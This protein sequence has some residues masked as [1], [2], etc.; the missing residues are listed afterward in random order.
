[1]LVEDRRLGSPTNDQGTRIARRRGMKRN[2]FLQSAALFLLLG[3]SNLDMQVNFAA[4]YATPVPY[5]EFDGLPATRNRDEPVWLVP[6][7]D[8]GP[9]IAGERE[10][11]RTLEASG[12]K[13]VTTYYWPPPPTGI[14]AG[15]TAPLLR[16]KETTIEG[17]TAKPI[18]L[19]G[20]FSQTYRPQHHNFS[21]DFMFEPALEDGLSADILAELDAKGIRQIYVLNSL[22]MGTIDATGKITPL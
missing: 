20:Y 3:I 22:T 8:E 4:D 7:T 2:R 21:E 14:V 5:F 16:W 13:I 19:K 9:A 10:Q 15:Y 6:C 11:T 12:V 1:M 17:L 18:V